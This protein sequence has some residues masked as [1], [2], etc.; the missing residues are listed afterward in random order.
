[1][2]CKILAVYEKALLRERNQK[3]P[4]TGRARGRLGGRNRKLSETD[5]QEILT[6]LLDPKITVGDIAQKYGVSR[7]TLYKYI[8]SPSPGSDG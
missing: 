2:A 1:M 5:V 3:G 6:E 8:G 4:T 7:T